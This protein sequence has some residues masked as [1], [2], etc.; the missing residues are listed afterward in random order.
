VTV[1]E[2]PGREELDMAAAL[3]DIHLDLLAMRKQLAEIAEEESP[4]P[5]ALVE[6]AF[7]EE[8]QRRIAPGARQNILGGHALRVLEN[9]RDRTRSLRCQ[10][11]ATSALQSPIQLPKRLACPGDKASRFR[12][13]VDYGWGLTPV[14]ISTCAAATV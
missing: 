6:V 5:A 8:C 4:S 12:H 7:A 10:G 14:V 1:P 2:L 11:R 13:I 3:A 9:A